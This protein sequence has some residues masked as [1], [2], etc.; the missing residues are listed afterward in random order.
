MPPQGA[1][2]IPTQ[3]TSM[4]KLL[5]TL[6]AAAIGSSAFADTIIKKDGTV[7]EG[8]ILEETP[9]EV[10]IE[11]QFSATIKSKEVVKVA[12]IKEM[13]KLPADEK[14]AA[15][16]SA[17]LKVTEDGMTAADYEK[18][19]K[20]S[21]QPWLDKY[22][23]SKKRADVEALLKLY[24]DEL[25]K[26]KAGG[27]KVRGSWVTAEELKWNEYNIAARRLRVE[28]E[29]RLKKREYV[30]M[31]NAFAKM[32]AKYPA[33]VDYVPS[34]ELMKK[35]MAAVEGTIARA[36]EEQ[37]GY[38]AERKRLLGSQTPEK[39]KELE[40]KIKAEQAEFRKKLAEEKKDKIRLN[41]FDK[42][43]LKSIQDALSQAKKET[44]YLGKIDIKG[45]ADAAKKYEDAMRH[46]SEKQWLSAKSKLEDAIKVF[47]KDA[48]VKKML[49]EATRQAAAASGKPGA[50]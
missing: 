38:D 50:K 27:A 21:I 37:K 24:T 4:K 42:Y 13:K 44:E 2:T 48:G 49:D 30:E 23:T 25:A 19:I 11:V 33:A 35:N 9:A 36:I 45:M 29:A 39:K 34:L 43:D 3:T 12:D 16:L 7:L 14:E 6:L 5:F 46:I 28:M 20:L 18:A 41:S 17:K 1:T 40:D 26:V 32:D 22:K 15:E 8:T 31:Y 10:T 47:S